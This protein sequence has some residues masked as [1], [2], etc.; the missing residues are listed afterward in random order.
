VV[1]ISIVAFVLL[2][3]KCTQQQNLNQYGSNENEKKFAVG[4][5]SNNLD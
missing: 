3:R 1:I 2:R 4:K 5:N